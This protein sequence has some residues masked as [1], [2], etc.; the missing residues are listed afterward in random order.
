MSDEKFYVQGK[1]LEKERFG[2][3]QCV[4]FVWN[5]LY[6]CNFRCPHCFFAGKW[7]EYALRD[8]YLS[9]PE[10]MNHWQRIADRYGR[11][12]LILNGGE[13]FMYPNFVELIAELAKIHY[14]INVTSNASGDIAAFVRKADPEKVSLSLSFHPPFMSIDTFIEKV[15]LLRAHSFPVGCL[16][17]CAFPGYIDKMEFYIDRAAAAGLQLKVIP[18]LGEYQGVRYPDG[19]SPHI[20]KL[21]GLDQTWSSNVSRKGSMCKAGYTSALLLPD[22]KVVRCGQVGERYIIGNFFD[23]AFRL[24]DTAMACDAEMCPCLEGDAAEA[25]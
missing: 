10:W 23:P 22:G 5:M 16:N 9:V 6:A 4:R 20:K 19:Y 21:L 25:Q 15:Q 14:P 1:S 12:S 18:Y 24:M 8:I 7:D 17:F 11:V 13:P 2:G 3:Q